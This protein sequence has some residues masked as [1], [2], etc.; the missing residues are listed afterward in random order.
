MVYTM[1][2]ALPSWLRRGI[3]PV[4]D[5]S[6]DGIHILDQS[7]NL[8]YANNTFLR[9]LGRDPAEGLPAHVR[10]WE[11]QKP[12][13]ELSALVAGKFTDERPFLTRHR[14]QD[15]SMYEAAISVARISHAGQTYLFCTVRDVSVQRQ[16]EEALREREAQY[17]LLVADL[18]AVIFRTDAEGRWRFLNPAWS[19][20]TGFAV[21]SSLGQ[22]FLDYVYPD[23]R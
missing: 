3:D 4:L 14:R 10:E 13:A 7:G 12:A 21:E 9:M 17:R 16:L 23:D 11:A 22:N 8:I 18:K 2:P 19:E 20:V 5:Q 1:N 6:P 15:G